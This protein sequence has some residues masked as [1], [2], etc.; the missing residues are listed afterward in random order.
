[1]WIRIKQ[2]V[3]YHTLADGH[4]ELAAIFGVKGVLTQAHRA[5][6]IEQHET[7]RSIMSLSICTSL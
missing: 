2:P 4:P 6:P 5:I 3:K 1:M 7:A